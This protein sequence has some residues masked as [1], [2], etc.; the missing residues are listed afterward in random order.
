[1]PSPKRAERSTT[2]N[3]RQDGGRG[4]FLLEN[5]QPNTLGERVAAR[6]DVARR[7]QGDLGLADEMIRT[8]GLDFKLD[9]E[10]PAFPRA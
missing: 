6:A 4:M 9:P 1:M 7:F 10:D 2:G 8:L 5:L 3:R